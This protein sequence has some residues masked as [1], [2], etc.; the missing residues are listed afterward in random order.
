MF[1]DSGKIIPHLEMIKALPWWSCKAEVPT[2]GHENNL[3][4]QGDIG[5]GV[6]DEYDRLSPVS[7]LTQQAHHSPIK[8]GIKTGGRFIK[9]EQ[10]RIRH[11]LHANADTLS[12]AATELAHPRQATMTDLKNI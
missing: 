8:S 2:S 9:K 6:G 1:I 4:A 11:Q 12:L 10:A 5:G 7:Q 3:V